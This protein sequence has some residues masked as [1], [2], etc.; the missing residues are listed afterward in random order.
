MRR[1]L[2]L[3]ATVVTALAV[4][5]G[6]ARPVHSIDGAPAQNGSA[7]TEAE[8]RALI[9]RTLANQN[10]DDEAL[11]VFE[12]IEHRIV[13]DHDMSATAGEDRTIRLIPTGAG[14]AR[15]TLAEHGR[16]ADPATIHA[17]MVVTEHMLETAADSANPQTKRDREKVERRNHDRRDLVSAIG[18]AYTF[19]WMGSEMRGGSAVSKYHLEPD[20]KYKANSIRTEFLKHANATAWVDEKSAQL[21]RLEA[22]LITDISFIGGVAGKVYRGGTAEIE[23]AEVEPGVWLPTLYKYDFTVRKFVFNSEVHERVEASHYKRIGPAKQAL[24]LIQ[25]ELSAGAAHPLQQ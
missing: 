8:R 1:T 18:E 24:T 7:L 20:P 10:N 21:V 14:S 15:I 4:V 6:H 17:Q 23:Q 16:P 19:T 11:Q 12:R 9:E 13:H 25:R 22:T 3:F 5:S 2:I